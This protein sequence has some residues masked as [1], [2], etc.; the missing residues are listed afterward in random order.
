MK[1]S[2][3]QGRVPCGGSTRACRWAGLVA[4]LLAVGCAQGLPQKPA[5][6][7]LDVP[8]WA[9]D[10][11]WYQIFVERFRNGD[12]SNDPTTHDIEGVTNE[13][14]PNGWR[15]T[16]WTQDWYRPDPW[17]KAAGKDFYGSVQFRRYGGDL[18]GVLDRLDYLQDLGVTAL[19]FNPVN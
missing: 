7:N 4:L 5:A 14:T 3:K 13:P 2:A 11:I 8:A 1:R 6:V 12:P 10:A 9:R 15:P 17:A 16:P 18:Q 19:F